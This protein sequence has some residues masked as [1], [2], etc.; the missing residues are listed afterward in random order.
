LGFFNLDFFFPVAFPYFTTTNKQTNMAVDEQLSTN[1]KRPLKD[2]H[3]VA[4]E[5]EDSGKNI[6]RS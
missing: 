6:S 2:D 5:D 4:A 3:Q 1:N